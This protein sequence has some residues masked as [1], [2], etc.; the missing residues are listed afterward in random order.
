MLVATLGTESI[1]VTKEFMQS[2][3]MALDNI[4]WDAASTQVQLAL[5]EYLSHIV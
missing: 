5:N 4:T 3:C 1:K 2:I